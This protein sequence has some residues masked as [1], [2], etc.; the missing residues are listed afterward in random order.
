MSTRAVTVCDVCQKDAGSQVPTGQR[1]ALACG[2]VVDVCLTCMDQPA[3]LLVAAINEAVRN[4]PPKP[5]DRFQDAQSFM[6][7][8]RGGRLNGES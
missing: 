8:A 2:S 3:R 6:G 4:A 7:V 1:I 5:R